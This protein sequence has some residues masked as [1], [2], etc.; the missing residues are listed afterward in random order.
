MKCRHCKKPV[1][2]YRARIGKYTCA[3]CSSSLYTGSRKDGLTSC[4]KC[5][6]RKPRKDMFTRSG[7]WYCDEGC[8]L[9]ALRK[10]KPRPTPVVLTAVPATALAVVAKPLT[11]IEMADRI[12]QSGPGFAGM[13]SDDE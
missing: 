8:A 6:Q 1:E 11:W 7:H 12:I 9:P 2:D 13:R 10:R 3:K 5:R 4:H